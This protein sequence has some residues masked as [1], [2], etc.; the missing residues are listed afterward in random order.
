MATVSPS[1]A[2]FSAFCTSSA[3]QEAAWMVSDLAVILTNV[4]TVSRAT[5]IPPIPLI[6][7]RLL[8]P[9]IAFTR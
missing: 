1:L 9:P 3:L 4:L 8:S 6:S 2:W 5:K 7:Q